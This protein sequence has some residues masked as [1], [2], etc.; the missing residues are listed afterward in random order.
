MI[1]ISTALSSDRRVFGMLMRFY[2]VV[3]G[4]LL[5]GRLRGGFLATV[6]PDRAWSDEPIPSNVAEAARPALWAFFL[7]PIPIGCGGYIGGTHRHGHPR[8]VGAGRAGAHGIAHR[9]LLFLGWFGTQV[10]RIE[11]AAI[12]VWRCGEA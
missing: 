10:V 5:V 6:R 2:L 11:P 7:W 4:V 9:V 1:D 12:A 3:A 8:P